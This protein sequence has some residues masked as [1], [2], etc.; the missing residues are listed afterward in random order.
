MVEGENLNRAEQAKKQFENGFHCAPAVL[1]TYSEHFG[2]EKAL[3]LKIASGFGAGI[4]RI[5][6]T[7]GAVTGALMVIGLKHGQVNS[8]DEEASQ[9]TY[10]LVKEFIDRFTT[11][12]GS[13][14]CRELIGYDLSDS[15]ELSLARNS[16]VFQN[17]CPSFV[18]DAAS[19]LE[20]VLNLR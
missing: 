15:K 4:G 6:R 18:Y 16:G 13:I 8:A 2:L 9:R 20:E 12:H 11:L 10:T 5:G 1:S 17:K 14:E 3:A 7:C 19:I